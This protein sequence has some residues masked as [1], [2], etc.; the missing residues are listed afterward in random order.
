MMHP[1][2]Q[3]RRIAKRK[4][5]TGCWSCRA[6]K[7][8]CDLTRPECLRCTRTPGKKCKGYGVSL[9]WVNASSAH[10]APTA[11]KRQ[12]MSIAPVICSDILDSSE[13]D[14]AVAWLETCE[15]KSISGTM[16][17]G[18]FGI[19]HV[20]SNCSDDQ[21]AQILR[22]DTTDEHLELSSFMSERQP[23]G[24]SRP[25]LDVSQSRQRHP[26][27]HN[28]VSA[29]ATGYLDGT[30]DPSTLSVSCR[31]LQTSNATLL[32]AFSPHIHSTARGNPLAQLLLHHYIEHIATLLQPVSRPNNTYKS[33]HAPVALRA[34]DA[35][36]SIAGDPHSSVAASRVAVLFSLL[37]TSAVHM[38]LAKGIGSKDLFHQLRHEAYSNLSMALEDAPI[39][40]VS[41]NF[42]LGEATLLN[43][44]NIMSAS[45]TL[46]TLDVSSLY[47]SKA[48]SAR[49]TDQVLR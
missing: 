14:A 19:F 37:A 29:G 17:S 33:I 49:T 2:D 26:T 8:K 43:L 36:C 42:L 9:T 47:N 28:H 6:S 44:E 3:K 41:I 10:Q 15:T 18:P 46:V 13:I 25:T 4:T 31:A 11:I 23:C 21:V 16:L 20:S 22:D 27:V 48:M 1:Q 45:L 24:S 30:K 32:N 12:A 5:F 40:S 39:R 38:R 34:L 35:L 7:V